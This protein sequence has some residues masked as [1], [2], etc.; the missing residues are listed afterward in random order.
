[1]NP[2]VVSEVTEDGGTEIKETSH[3]SNFDMSLGRLDGTLPDAPNTDALSKLFKPRYVLNVTTADGTVVPFVYKR[4]DPMTLMMTHDSPITVSPDAI[5]NAESAQTRLEEIADSVDENNPLTPELQA[6][7]R[8]LL[9]SADTQDTYK[10][11]VFM[12]KT[13]VQTGVISPQITDELY[14][15]LDDDIIDALFQAIRGGVTSD[16]ELVEHFRGDA[17]Q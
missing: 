4:V 8:E 12:K 6:E 7:M 11:G 14:E 3:P 13:T 16:A 15:N 17:A 10:Q 1:M 2:K 9:T 5:R